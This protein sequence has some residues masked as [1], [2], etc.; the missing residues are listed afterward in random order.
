MTS[1]FQLQAVIEA[2][3]FGDDSICPWELPTWDNG[4]PPIRLSGE[5]THPEIGLVFAQLV[6]YNRLDFFTNSQATLKQI[7]EAEKLVLPGGIQATLGDQVIA[8]SCCCGLETW[9]E[10]QVFLKTGRSP[11]LGHDPSP[12]LEMEDDLIRIWSDRGFGASQESAFHIE[13][14]RSTFCSSLQV[15]ESELQAFLFCIDSWARTVGFEQAEE[16]TQQFDQCFQIGRRLT[17]L[18]V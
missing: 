2:P 1:A 17:E 13:T 12:G 11:W 10:W 8:P 14:K 6:Q 16:L 3:Y 18:L 5:L 15:A 9:R 7:I 4:F